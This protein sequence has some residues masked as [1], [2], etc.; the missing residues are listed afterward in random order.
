ME[1]TVF[2]ET[3]DILKIQRGSPTNEDLNSGR[4]NLKMRIM[5]EG[6][7]SINLRKRRPVL[8]EQNHRYRI[9]FYKDS[10]TKYFRSH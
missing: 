5:Q 10:V 6:E 8:K 2:G 9:I 3:L 7:N 4:Q 1:T